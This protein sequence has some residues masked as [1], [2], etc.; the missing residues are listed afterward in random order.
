MD[1]LLLIECVGVDNV[2]NNG[3]WLHL[4]AKVGRI[5]RKETW[6]SSDYRRSCRT[7]VTRNQ[8]DFDRCHASVK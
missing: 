4:D 8:T 3:Q 2:D 1:T 7:I 5:D 6:M